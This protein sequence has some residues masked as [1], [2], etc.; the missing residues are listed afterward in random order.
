MRNSRMAVSAFFF[1]NGFLYAN[2]MARLPELQAFFNISN[3]VLGTLLF[4]VAAGAMTAMPFTGWLTTK[5]GSDGI[6]RVSGILFCIF[7]PFVVLY[8]D[9]VFA[10]I[11]L[12]LLGTATGSMDVC[13]NGQA[14]YVERLWGKPIISSFHAVFSIGMALGAGSGGLFS[15]FDISLLTHLSVLCAACLVIVI[16]ASFHLISDKE[17]TDES[18]ESSGFMWPSKAIIPLGIIALCSM[19]G[20]GSMTDWSAIY[21]NTVVGKEPTFSAIAFGVYAGGMTLGRLFGDKLTTY[22]GRK[23]LLKYDAICAI[24]GLG[25]ALVHVSVFTAFLGFFLV[26][27]GVATAVPIIFSLA[28]NTKGVKPAVGIAM[29]TSIGYTGFFVGPPSIGFLSDIFGLRLALSVV[30]LL[31]GLMLYLVYKYIDEKA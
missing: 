3:S 15:H 8:P 24:I 26:G 4:L 7:T 12:F 13:A 10:G 6:T 9:V 19:I 17:T 27:L 30:L 25:I 1:V 5:Y 20:E 16:I 29:A 23:K 18:E 14:V 21:M 11:F 22:F 2:L 28:G 31:F